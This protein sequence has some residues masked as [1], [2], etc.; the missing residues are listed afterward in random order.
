MVQKRVVLSFILLAGSIVVPG[1]QPVKQWSDG[2]PMPIPKPTRAVRLTAD[3]SPMPIPKP[4]AFAADG[5]PMPIPK[6]TGVIGQVA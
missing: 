2:S 3:G 6:P 1:Y 4:T 5:S